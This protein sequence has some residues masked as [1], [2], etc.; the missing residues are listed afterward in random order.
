MADIST[1]TE[2]RPIRNEGAD[3]DRGEQARGPRRVTPTSGDLEPMPKSDW[4]LGVTREGRGVG[5][6]YG[7]SG[8]SQSATNEPRKMAAAQD[9]R[10]DGTDE[11]GRFQGDGPQH[12]D[13]TLPV[14]NPMI[15]DR[16]SGGPQVSGASGET[17]A[18]RPDPTRGGPDGIG[19]AIFGPRAGGKKGD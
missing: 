16:S 12:G 19:D 17:N 5:P 1:T 4:K 13:G 2:K 3:A 6:G 10:A 7:R 11:S 15:S 18:A 9:G 14:P 8:G